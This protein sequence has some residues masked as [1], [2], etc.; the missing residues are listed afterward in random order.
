MKLLALD[1]ATENCSVALWLDGAIV[2]RVELAGREHS[3]RLPLM[4]DAVLAEAGIKLRQIDGLVCGIGPGSFAGVRIGVSF[5]KGMALGLE[6]PVVPVSS[7]A[8]LAQAALRESPTA[9]V[10]AAID[11]RM[12]EVY[13]G[14]YRG[15]GGIAHLEGSER[16]CPPQSVLNAELSAV[17]PKQTGI[18]FSS[19]AQGPE[20]DSHLPGNDESFEWIGTGTGW[21]AHGEALRQAFGGT[22]LR[23]NASALPRA[24]DG[25]H[26]VA[27]DFPH[28]AI[29]ASRLVPAYLRNNVA[30]TR[31]EQ[32]AAREAARK[33]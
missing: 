9:T 18:T 29:D 14:C 15:E 3:S 21:A 16:V 26:Q 24:A 31:I 1:T 25:L 27:A 7:L 12:G 11:A 28:H 5:V 33:R 20:L 10:L 17:I 30:L 8:M 19:G 23:I 4:V 32:A 22:P 13:F 2:E 6:L